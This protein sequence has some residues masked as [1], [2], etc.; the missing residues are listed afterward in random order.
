VRIELEF[1]GPIQDRM[2]G[3]RQL[4]EID[5]APATL[6]ALVAQLAQGLEGG[7]CLQADHLRIAVNDR[8][9]DRNSQLA[10]ADGDRIA[11]L[12]PFSGG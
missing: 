4:A 9:V 8:L 3:A 2:G 7:D 12:S 6:D 10:L 5:G 1:Y 11:F